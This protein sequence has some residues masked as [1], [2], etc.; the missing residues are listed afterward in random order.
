M[1]DPTHRPRT[2]SLL[3]SRL[4]VVCPS[5]AV[6]G[7][8]RLAPLQA[9]WFATGSYGQVVSHLLRGYLQAGGAPRR[10][11]PKTQGSP[12]P[13]TAPIA[14]MAMSSPPSTTRLPGISSSPTSGW[15]P[16]HRRRRHA[17]ACWRPR[18]PWS[19][20]P[21]SVGAV[22]QCGVSLDVMLLLWSGGRSLWRTAKRRLMNQPL[23]TAGPSCAW[24]AGIRRLGGCAGRET[25]AIYRAAGGPSAQ[26][27]AARIAPN[28]V[29]LTERQSANG[30]RG[31]LPRGLGSR[32]LIWLL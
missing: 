30:Q 14:S 16:C 11:H 18:E 31:D 6:A 20:S 9:L 28:T 29:V 15:A 27:G 4:S 7:R 1:R 3:F 10:W 13:G 25:G 2:R 22:S 19:A 26:Q 23:S 32:L 5:G 12:S 21:C 8:R 17:M 24:L